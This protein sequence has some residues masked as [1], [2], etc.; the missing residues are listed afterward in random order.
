MAKNMSTEIT[1]FLYQLAYKQD[2]KRDYKPKGVINHHDVGHLLRSHWESDS[3][4]LRDGRRRVELALI[5]LLLSFT[6]GRPGAVLN[7]ICHPGEALKY[8][9]FQIV[10]IHNENGQRLYTMKISYHLVKGNWGKGKNPTEFH[11]FEDKESPIYCPLQLFFA[12]A[13]ADNAFEMVKTREDIE[14]LFSSGDARRSDSGV[15]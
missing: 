2:L 14:N 7:T 4:R 8:K 15:S 11:C 1:A 6:A 3:W 12:L 9:N 13:L 10:A 5:V